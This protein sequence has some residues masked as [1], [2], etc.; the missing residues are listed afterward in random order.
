MIGLNLQNYAKISTF[1]INIS[2][3]QI[4]IMKMNE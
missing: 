1:Q 4:S 2:T 3:F